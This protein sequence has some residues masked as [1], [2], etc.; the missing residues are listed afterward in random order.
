MRQGGVSA[1]SKA[2]IDLYDAAAGWLVTDL[3][4]PMPTFDAPP[5]Q[6]QFLT[7]D[8][9]CGLLKCSRSTVKRHL[10]SGRLKKRKIGRLV[11]IDP[12]DLIA[13]IEDGARMRRR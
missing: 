8:D 13:F 5:G 9:V 10:A 12:A 11:R 1:G 2:R 7:I 4:P 6:T 3:R